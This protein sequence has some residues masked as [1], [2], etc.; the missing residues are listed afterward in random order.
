M[1]API[2][3]SVI[4]LLNNE[5]ISTG[6]PVLGFLNPWLYDNADA[7]YDITFGTNPGCKTIGFSATSGW[8]PVTGLGTPKY[9]LL[10]HAAGLSIN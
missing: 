3:A 10:R 1:S 6:K 2:F 8:G 4:A 5:L 9:E 7:F